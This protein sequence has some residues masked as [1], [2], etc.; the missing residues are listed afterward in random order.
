M[1]KWMSR[2]TTLINKN[3]NIPSVS[4]FILILI[5]FWDRASVLLTEYLQKGWLIKFYGRHK[6]KRNRNICTDAIQCIIERC[7]LTQSAPRL[8]CTLLK[9]ES[10]RGKTFFGQ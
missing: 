4:D 8:A 6:E 9:I 2:I 7:E 5:L 1:T 10:L 3:F